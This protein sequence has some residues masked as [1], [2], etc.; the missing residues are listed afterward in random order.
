ML[1]SPVVCKT[2]YE[3]MKARPDAHDQKI[4]SRLKKKRELHAYQN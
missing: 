4:P 3:Q 1:M 2:S